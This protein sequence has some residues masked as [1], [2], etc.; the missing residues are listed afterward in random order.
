MHTPNPI[1]IFLVMRLNAPNITSGQGEPENPVRKWCST[2]QRLS[3]PTWSASSHC[4][5]VSLY[6]LFQSISAPWKGRC[7]SYKIPNCISC[8]LVEPI[9]TWAK[10]TPPDIPLG[11][12]EGL[13]PVF[14]EVGDPLGHDHGGDIS[15]GPDAV[16]HYGG[17]YY[18]QSGQPPYL[19][20][21]VHH[22][23]GVRVGAHFAGAANVV[24]GANFRSIHWCKA[25]SSA[26]L[27]SVGSIRS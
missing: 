16:G 15:I 5:R 17:V 7:I 13:L 6:R 12:K 24:L 1:L 11:R 21:L 2:N 3:N 20:L 22:R 19:T 27:A 25:P 14:D 4:S 9:Q 8:L 10:Y 26:R 18:P 23:H